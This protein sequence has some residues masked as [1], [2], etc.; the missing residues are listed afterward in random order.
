MSMRGTE[1]SSRHDTLK[2]TDKDFWNYC[3]DDFA[4]VDVPTVVDYVRRTTGQIRVGYIGHSQATF[5][6]FGLLAS[7]PGY[8][9]VIE[10]VVAVAPVSYFDHITS[11][12][13]LL[14]MATLTATDKNTHGPF[15]TEAHKMRIELAKVCGNKKAK[16]V[17]STCDLIEMLISG[18]G[19]KWKK[20]YYSHLPFRTS[21]KILRHFG[22]LIKHKR[23]MMY[24]YGASENLRLYGT[25][26]SP[27]YPIKE[28]RSKS[29]VLVSTKTDALSQ[30]EDVERFRSNLKVAVYKNIIIDKAFDHFDIILNEEAGRLVFKPILEVFRQFE[31]K[32]GTCRVDN[33]NYKEEIEQVVEKKEIIEP[34]ANV[35]SVE[36]VPEAVIEKEK[37]LEKEQL[38]ENAPIVE[39]EPIVAN[40]PIVATKPLVGEEPIV[41]SQ[42]IVEQNS[43]VEPVQPVAVTEPLEVEAVAQAEP[44]KEAL[45]ESEIDEN[46]LPF[47][48]LRGPA[49]RRPIRPVPRG[50]PIRRPPPLSAGRKGWPRWNVRHFW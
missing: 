7:R 46:R 26:D 11:I 37:L 10:P 44:A 27:S 22:Q 13:R 5:S 14:F 39:K 36:T 18:F 6:V 2:D 19:K 29:I 24:D 15:P 41:A 8:A 31:R 48:K 32:S 45:F 42:P 38:V 12:A 43:I 1:W 33:P 25:I 3:L 35:A 23:F 4:L 20:G 30:P 50:V 17:K 40:E 9:D 34:T 28:I 16:L 21:L 49:L 47:N